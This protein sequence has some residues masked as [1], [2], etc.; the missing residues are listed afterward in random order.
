MID[1]SKVKEEAEKEVA[2]EKIKAAKTLVKDKLKELDDAKEV[3][4]NV[5]RELED[6]YAEIAQ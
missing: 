5:Q 6:L 2:E 4:R 3:V 1:I